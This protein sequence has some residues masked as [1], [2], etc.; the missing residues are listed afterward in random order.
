LTETQIWGQGPVCWLT[1]Y[2]TLDAADAKCIQEVLG[3]FLYYAWAV[4]STL[5]TALGTI[6]TQQAKHTQDTMEAITQLLNY[7]ATH[8]NTTV[9]YHTSAWSYG[10]T[11][12]HPTSLP[13]KVAP[14]ELDITF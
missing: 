12:M 9:C 8:P 14:A 6:A 4:S 7:F 11:A 5:I 10:S 13:L 1:Q 3:V 2:Y